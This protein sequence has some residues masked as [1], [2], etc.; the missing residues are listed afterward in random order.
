MAD[1]V[2][3][4]AEKREG[5]GKNDSR[6]L[7]AEGK[8]PVVVYG[9]GGESVAGVAA[10]SDLAAVLRA[11]GH[12]AVFTLDMEG[13]GTGDVMFQDR[14]IDPLKGRLVHADLRRI[15]LGEKMEMTVPIHIV[16]DA[17]GLAEDGAVLNQ[18]LHEIKILVEP[19][20]VP[21]AIEV[22]VTNLKVGESIHISDIKF[23]E[24]TEV[25]EAPETVVASI[26]IVREEE[27]EPQ[28]E[29]SEPEVIGEKGDDTGGEGE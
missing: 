29:A 11:S 3:V 5:R 20:K 19:S 2:T 23:D 15:A 27:L 18:P 9:G 16:G 22:D 7:R 21:E 10:L 17:E 12:N 6:R 28:L 1:K 14:Q 8:I 25:H 13:E 4:K 26:V 24:G